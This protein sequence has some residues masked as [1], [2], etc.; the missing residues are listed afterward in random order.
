MKY[1]AVSF[2]VAAMSVSSL[3]G[4]SHAQVSSE[5]MK[6]DSQ[7]GQAAREMS[8]AQVRAQFKKWLDNGNM[9]M[10]SDGTAYI[11]DSHY[12]SELSAEGKGYQCFSW[13]TANPGTGM[14]VHCRCHE[15]ETETGQ[16]AIVC[17]KI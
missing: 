4:I 13:H 3:I 14:A 12:D 15:K 1:K 6:Q 10:T 11:D 9:V 5:N 2:F 17:G 7:Q 8:D 16:E